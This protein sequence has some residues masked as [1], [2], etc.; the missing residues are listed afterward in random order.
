MQLRHIAVLIAVS[1]CAVAQTTLYNQSPSRAFGQPRLNTISSGNPNLVEGREFFLPQSVALDKSSS[2]FKV[3]VADTV[4]NRV[5]GWRDASAVSKGNPADLVIGQ[6]DLLSTRPGGPGTTLTTGLSAPTAVGVDASGNVYVADFANNRILRY[7]RPFDQTGQIPQ[8]DLVIGQ[9]TV[10]S[11]NSPN[12]GAGVPSAKTISFTGAGGTARTTIT[13][14]AQGNLWVADVGNHRVLRYPASQLAAGNIEPEANLVLGQQNFVTGTFNEANSPGGNVRLNKNTLVLPS[15]IAFSEAGDLY[16]SDA[17]A[18][19]LYFRGPFATNGQPATR[20]LGIPT[21]TSAN[22]PVLRAFDGCPAAPPQPCEAALGGVTAQ[23]LRIPPE[24]IA[25]LNNSLYVADTGNNRIVK[26]D[27]PATWP[28]ECTFT[29]GQ[30]CPAGTAL[31]PTGV[32][33]I[34]Q[35]NGQSVRA[36]QGGLP[37]ANTLSQP[38]SIAFGGTDMWVADSSNHRILVFPQAGNTYTSA[39]RVLGQLE[40]NYNAPNLVEGKELF[41]YDPISRLGFAGVAVDVTREPPPLYVADALNNRILCFRDSRRVIAGVTMPD[42]VIGQPDLLT[43]TA[44]T[45]TGTADQPNDAT[46]M[47]PIGL[48]VDKVGDLWVADSGNSRVLRFSRPFEQEGRIRANLVLGQSSMFSKITDAL[49]N[50]MRT[51][52]GLAFTAQGH[53]AVS[54]ASHHR[55]LI[56]RKPEGGDFRTG[57]NADVVIGQQDFTSSSAGNTTNRFNSPRGIAV[58]TSDRLYVADAGNNRISI[59]SGYLGGEVDPSARFTPSIGNPQAVAVS[60]LTGQ[61]WVTDVNAGRLLRF[62]IFEDWFLTGQSIGSIQTVGTPLAVTLDANDNPVIAEAINRVSMYYPQAAFSNAASYVTRGLTPGGLAYMARYAPQ[63]APGTEAF[64]QGFPLPTTLGNI[65]VLLNDNPV[66]LFQVL[67]DR[68]SFQVPWSAPSTGTANIELIRA[69][70]GE[71][72]AAGTFPMRTADPAFF[73]SNAQGFGQLAA[74]NQDGSVNSASNPA[75][76]GSIIA[77]FGTGLGPVDNPPPSGQVPSGTLSA[78]GLPRVSMANP[79][80]GVLPDSAIKYFGLVNWF[81]GVFQLNVEIPDAVPPSNTVNV[82]LVWKD[83]FSTEGPSGRVVTTIAV[84]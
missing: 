69:S 81:P 36:N 17:R 71:V 47:V 11:G 45:F 19:V 15:G 26:Y 31:S 33:F 63:F 28:T 8:P 43:T 56:F 79:G 21:P 50:Q 2:P 58:D 34:G 54:D 61:V 37:G 62:P 80:P 83:F 75:P 48:L 27:P 40:F 72:L 42:R 35:T 77:L 5:L 10:S 32:A 9:R 23:N 65:Q 16:I 30:L 20:I 73:T 78:P 60:P 57:Q 7:P 52:W 82:G 49:R 41:I 14:D 18:R 44:N 84:R 29:A 74:L 3:Y 67:A 12:Q 53:L 59:F 24:G 70:T 51:P 76:R 22:D 13:F 68:V 39:N 38:V 64:S 55:V 46:L 1:C 25:V 4:N 66:P 6:L